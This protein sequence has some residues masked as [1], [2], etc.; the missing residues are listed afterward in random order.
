MNG[1]EIKCA[2]PWIGVTQ[3]EV[4]RSWSRTT[5]SADT[6]KTL[7]YILLDERCQS[8]SPQLPHPFVQKLV[9]STAPARSVNK[10]DSFLSKV[11]T[12]IIPANTTPPTHR[13]FA[14]RMSLRKNLW[15]RQVLYIAIPPLYK[16]A[17]GNWRRWLPQA[18]SQRELLW[19]WDTLSCIDMLF[20]FFRAS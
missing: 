14:E 13:T 11:S 20:P 3:T 1:K 6:R 7:R 16:R 18:P 8:Q 15:C 10:R 9:H 12:P 5:S 17:I 19:Y 4:A 2:R